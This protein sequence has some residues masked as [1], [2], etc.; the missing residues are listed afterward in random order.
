MYSPSPR[1]RS[2]TLVSPVTICTPA[3]L[4]AAEAEAIT[5][6]SVP[7][8]RPSS[9]ISA[10]E[11][12]FGSAPHIARSF[13][14]P[15]TASLPMSPPG[16]SSGVTTKL[17]VE[18]ASPPGSRAPSPSASSALLPKAGSISSSMSELVFRPP[19]P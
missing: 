14:V 13:T 17:S 2:T 3:S 7:V 16:N 11:R 1:P 4:A 15:Q 5:R 9:I 8:G 10:S 18:K 19:E 12:Y 6:L